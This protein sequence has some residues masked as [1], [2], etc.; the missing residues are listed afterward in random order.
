MKS[1]SPSAVFE[2]FL[3]RTGELG[4]ILRFVWFRRGESELLD[5]SGLE[6]L[7]F[8]L[9]LLLKLLVERVEV[10]DWIGLDDDFIFL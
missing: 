3:L 7:F 8:L 1:L 2:G 5:F 4:V 6:R 10:R 9:D